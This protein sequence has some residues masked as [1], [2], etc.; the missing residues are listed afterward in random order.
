MPFQ[1]DQLRGAGVQAEA[2]SV[3]L[4]EVTSQRERCEPE[5]ETELPRRA[6]MTR[7]SPGSKSNSRSSCPSRLPTL[8]KACLASGVRSEPGGLPGGV[9]DR[10]R[11]APPRRCCPCRWKARR[12]SSRHGGEGFPSLIIVLQGYGVTVR[13]GWHNAHQQNGGHHQ[14]VQDGARRAGRQLRTEPARRAPIRR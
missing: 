5:R 14:H 13:P 10:A 3:H 2:A 8:Q 7:T 4:R 12:T 6:R 11:D 9:D 1:V